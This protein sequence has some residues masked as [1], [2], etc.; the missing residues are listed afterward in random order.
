MAQTTTIAAVR[1]GIVLASFGCAAAF[2]Q[3]RLA[4]NG[5][6]SAMPGAHETGADLIWALPDGASAGV[7]AHAPLA[8]RLAEPIT[9]DGNATIESVVVYAY[10]QGAIDG[11]TIDSLGLELWQ[12]RPGDAGSTRVAGD[13]EANM[14]SSVEPANAFVAMTGVSFTIDRPV[15]ALTAGDLDWAVEA[16]D[17]WLVWT[18]EGSLDGGPY[19]PYLGD[20]A[21]PVIGQA[22]QRVLGAWRPARNKTEGGVQVSL[23]YEVYGSFTCT[24]DCDDDGA[25]TIFDFLCFQNAFAA[26]ESSADCDGDGQVSMDDF[27]C[28]QA[29][30]MA[31]CG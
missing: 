6:L 20:D 29:A 2:G 31:G 9:L 23:P 30:F 7:S 8:Y 26:G 24:A 3:E 15:F 16:G 13:I 21:Q 18:M 4:S 22:R 12:G 27:A 25:L 28:F 14:L 11:P 5:P 19:S 17:Y 1:T 10:Q